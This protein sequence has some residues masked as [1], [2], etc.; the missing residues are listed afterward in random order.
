MKNES[1]MIISIDVDKALEKTQY[2]FIIIKTCSRLVIEG[3][4]LNIIK[5]VCNKTTANIMLNGK[6]K[7]K[8]FTLKI[9]NK[10]RVS[11]AP[12]HPAQH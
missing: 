2:V 5:A 11:T 8:A 3:K 7:M 9:R 4:Y 12:K 10:T 1:H 6:K